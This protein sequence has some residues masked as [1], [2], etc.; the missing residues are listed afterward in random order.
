M[1]VKL[2][3]LGNK[4]PR[5]YIGNGMLLKSGHWEAELDQLELAVIVKA[6]SEMGMLS[7]KYLEKLAKH[8]D[9]EGIT[10]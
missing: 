1:K 9:K 4:Q 2:S 8:L 6:L 10:W 7:P 5:C 3:I